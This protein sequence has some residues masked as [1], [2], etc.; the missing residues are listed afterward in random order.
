[1]ARA[2]VVGALL[3]AVVGCGGDDDGA[4]PVVPDDAAS[5]T[6]AGAEPPSAARR[7]AATT[8]V[9][10]EPETVGT[11]AQ[12]YLD[13]VDA[14]DEGVDQAHEDLREARSESD[15]D[16]VRTAAAE[17]AD[18]ARDIALVLERD[19]WPESVASE[20][21]DYVDALL[22]ETTVLDELARAATLEDAAA[23]ME[24]PSILEA[25]AAAARLRQE[26]GLPTT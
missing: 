3:V 21:D 18:A 5:T 16:E 9:V 25:G 26:L 11:A 14:P 7:P 15:L 6:G 4:A 1:M 2:L 22:R 20:I 19:T 24:D 8:T 12:R 23:L 13:L 10:V 17:L